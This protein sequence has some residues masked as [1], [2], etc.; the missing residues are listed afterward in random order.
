M[1]HIFK[2]LCLALSAVLLLAPMSLTAFAFNDKE[3]VSEDYYSRKPAGENKLNSVIVQYKPGAKAIAKAEEEAAVR[4]ETLALQAQRAV[5]RAEENAAAAAALAADPSASQAQIMAVRYVEAE[6]QL[7]R[8]MAEAAEKAAEDFW[9]NSNGRNKNIALEINA[10]RVDTIEALDIDIIE[11]PPGMTLADMIEL[12]EDY[13]N[14]AFVEADCPAY[15]S[16]IP[17]DEYYKTNQAAFSALKM[18]DVWDLS[19]GAKV[20]VAVL[21]TGISTNHPDLSGRISFGY[22]FVSNNSNTIDENGHGTR[23][24]GIIGANGNNLT[25]I[26]GINW[27][28]KIMPVKVMNA[29]GTGTMANVARGIIY[30]ADNGADII[31]LSLGGPDDSTVLSKAIDYAYSKNVIIVASTGND[32]SAAG[33]DYPA[34][35]DK[36]IGVGASAPVLKEEYS[37]GGQGI[38]ISTPGGLYSTTMN[39]SYAYSAGTSFSAAVVSGVLSLAKGFNPNMTPADAMRLVIDTATPAAAGGWNPDTG[40]GTLNAPELVK[41]ASRMDASKAAPKPADTTPPV[42][43]LLGDLNMRVDQDGVFIDPGFRA[44]DDDGVV[45]TDKVAVTGTVYINL[46]GF[47]TRLYTVADDAGNSSAAIRIVEIVAVPDLDEFEEKEQQKEKE[48]KEKEQKEK[49]QQKSAKPEDEEDLSPADDEEDLYAEENAAGESADNESVISESSNEV[50]LAEEPAI[51]EEAYGLLEIPDADAISGLNEEAAEDEEIE[52]IDEEDVPLAA[53]P[54]GPGSSNYIIYI[55]L[56]VIVV[57][58]A[59]IIVVVRQKQKNRNSA[60]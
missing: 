50:P 60:A 57:A 29:S 53:A 15:V 55:S 32:G 23:V 39:R 44:V 33:V 14:I 43:T 48:Q 47:Y 1:R 17:N 35:Y 6:K 19:K 37:N 7:V 16:Y 24:A 31:N 46:P 42:L 12:A 22:N 30:A 2:S 28:V 34:R 3:A 49:E 11:L 18:E 9:L 41:A 26:A 13:D 45:V 36:V 51:E 38:T 8:E 58:A 56:L 27:D 21:D 5:Q 59:A 10:P 25:G 54:V 40:Y 4:M 20:T 52:L